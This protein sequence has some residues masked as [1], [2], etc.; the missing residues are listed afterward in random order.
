MNNF[1]GTPDELM[2]YLNNLK[3]KYGNARIFN[4]PPDMDG[5]EICAD[6]LRELAHNRDAWAEKTQ[7]ILEQTRLNRE[8]YERNVL[9]IPQAFIDGWSE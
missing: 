6:S 4:R 8:K 3:E 5:C 1:E 2:E 7:E 9:G